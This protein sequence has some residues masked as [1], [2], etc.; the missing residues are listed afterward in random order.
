M[1]F[2]V[3]YLGFFLVSELSN[4]FAAEETEGQRIANILWVP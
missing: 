4:I 1:T 3:L 2:A